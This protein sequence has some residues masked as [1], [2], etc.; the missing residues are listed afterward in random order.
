MACP[1]SIR[2]SE[3][4]PNYESD[5]AREGTVAHELAECWLATP[6]GTEVPG[7]E[8]YE[9]D[10]IE[11]VRVFV[12]YCRDLMD[13]ADRYWLEH[14]FNLAKLN[15]P[16]P[17]FGYNGGSAGKNPSLSAPSQ[18][19]PAFRTPFVNGFGWMTA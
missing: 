12:D 16:A 10:M 15:P 18:P 13:R 11:G 4:Q 1:G 9:E 8:K 19:R 17:M 14:G 6:S 2:L 5:Y 3:G 7:I